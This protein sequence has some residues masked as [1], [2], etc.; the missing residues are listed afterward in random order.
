MTR[1]EQLALAGNQPLDQIDPLLDALSELVKGARSLL[2]RG[3]RAKAAGDLE[4]AEV[5]YRQ[6]MAADP[7]YALAPHA[8]G[9]LL[10]DLG[11]ASEALSA[12]EQAVALDPNFPE[13]WFNLATA[14]LR[15]G[16]I[17][18]ADEAYLKVLAI[19]PGH[20]Q[21]RLRRA[22]IL[23]QRGDELATRAELKRV[24]DDDPTQREA[25]QSVVMLELEG[26]HEA[27][28][29]MVLDR[30]L[31]I[32]QDGE[33]RAELQLL[34]AHLATVRGDSAAASAAYQAAIDANRQQ[35]LAWYNLGQL[36]WASG[37]TRDAVDSLQEAVRLQP[38]DNRFQLALSR[39]L[40]SSGDW[41]A[42]RQALELAL[43]HQPEEPT[44]SA[45][46]IE[47]LAASPSDE[48][49]DGARALA[50]AQQMAREH[51]DPR[52]IE[53]T[54]MS[55]AELG[56]FEQAADLARRLLDAPQTRAAPEEVQVRLRLALA[57]YTATRPWR[58]Q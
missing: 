43:Q 2:S 19:D 13:A 36:Q 10:V 22:A 26:G 15:G 9:L 12:F 52:Y 8:L 6:A 7:D 17:D 25:V 33:V 11:R 56:H 30:A 41:Q 39:A 3:H 20:Q 54:A 49:R 14:R 55:L 46:L 44:L 38:G 31:A 40:R 34:M 5:L 27:A 28:A 57:E 42:A 50:L 23:H 18:A 29:A 4:H 24:L 35:P 21:A 32:A 58:L 51:R 47:L 16:E 45:S 53:L 1:R 48:V 37:Q